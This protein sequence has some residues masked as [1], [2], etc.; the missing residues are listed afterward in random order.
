MLPDKR[1]VFLFVG[2]FTLFFAIYSIPAPGLGRSISALASSLAGSMI[3]TRGSDWL[4]L[5]IR[6]A[7]DDR[8]FD[9]AKRDAPW[10]IILEARDR[11]AG[12]QA[13]VDINLRKSFYIPMAVFT[14]LTLASPIWKGRRGIVVLSMG[15]ALLLVP[16]AVWIVAPT[17]GLL[18]EAAV[19]DLGPFEQGLIRFAYALSGPPGMIYAIP[20]LVW[21]VLV[22][23]TRT[24]KHFTAPDAICPETDPLRP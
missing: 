4:V 7:L 24:R 21:A 3:T 1:G 8:D 23:S 11:S 20:L 16:I 2:L 18:Y 19:I 14:A 10:T 17:L 15:L 9:P 6:P 5:G 22:W 12:R 13:R